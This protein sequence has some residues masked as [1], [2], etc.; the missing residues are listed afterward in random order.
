MEYGPQGTRT[1]SRMMNET[2]VE[3]TGRKEPAQVP[4]G[5]RMHSGKLRAK[6]TRADPSH[7]PHLLPTGC[8]RAILE[9]LYVSTALKQVSEIVPIRR[10]GV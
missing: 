7:V 9:T 4:L 5:D 3:G 10:A 2:A 8:R 6:G 1:A